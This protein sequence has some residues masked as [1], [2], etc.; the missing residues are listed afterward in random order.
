MVEKEIAVYK[1]A[2]NLLRWTMAAAATLADVLPRVLSFT[3]AKRLLGVFADHIAHFP[4][5][6]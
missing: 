5:K 2:Y 1:L 3:G 6:C 4:K